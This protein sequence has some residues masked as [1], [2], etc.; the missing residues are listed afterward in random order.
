MCVPTLKNKLLVKYFCKFPLS[1]TRRL[2]ISPSLDRLSKFSKPTSVHSLG[3][4]SL[5]KGLFYNSFLKYEFEKTVF[6]HYYEL[7]VVVS[8]IIFSI[9]FK[10]TKN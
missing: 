4:K 8:S 3:L 1:V 9:F 6:L 2:S 10:K 7:Y 5:P